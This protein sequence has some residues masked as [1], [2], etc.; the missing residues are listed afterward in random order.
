MEMK[1]R[2]YLRK[3]ALFV[4]VFGLLISFISGC[5]GSGAAPS[6][7]AAASQNAA[8]VPS[9]RIAVQP[10]LLA[11]PTYYIMEEG[12]DVKNGFK[13]ERSVYVNGTLI[14]E[15][16]GA[17][18]WDVATGGTSAVYG[19]ANFGAQVVANIDL[20][21]GGTGAYVRPGSR[22]A[23]IKDGLG[24]GLYGNAAVLKGAKCL[25][26]VGTLNQLNVLKWLEK[27]GLQPDDVEFVHMD[28]ASAFQAF[29]AGEG[30]ITAFSPPLTFNA[31]EEG[32][33]NGAGGELLGMNIWDPL[34]ANPRTIDEKYD[35][36]VAYVKL[37]YEVFDMFAA[38]QELLAEWSIKWQAANGA[39]L[40][41]EN[42][43][44]EVASRPFMTSGQ[45]RQAPV[46][47]TIYEMAVFFNQTGSLEK[48]EL[49][50]VQPNLRKDV[51]QKVFGL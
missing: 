10:Y 46:G 37:M 4:L 34:L 26:P 11:V 3:T 50:K 16:L 24:T 2:I 39:Q 41:I 6:G 22:I 30:D 48:D 20:C 42:A 19:I 47:D 28:N 7:G 9:L 29:K 12:L 44:R 21:S 51:I 43:R 36:I 1:R 35:Q 38:N 27:A 13:L 14:N 8:E 25:L 40:T 49:A 17:S 15:A 33:I 23:N 31:E 18:L 32:W 5:G 45:A